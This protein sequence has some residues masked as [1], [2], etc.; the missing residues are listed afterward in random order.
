MCSAQ[1]GPARPSLSSLF[2][3]VSLP[4]AG[5]LLSVEQR[6]LIRRMTRLFIEIATPLR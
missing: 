5:Y 1:R 4:A 2:S 3:P 6:V